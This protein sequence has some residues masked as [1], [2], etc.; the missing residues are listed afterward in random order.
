MLYNSAVAGESERGEHL[1]TAI[2][3]LCVELGGSIT[4]EHG[5]GADKACSM[6]KMFSE[7]D[8]AVMKRLRSAFDPTGISNPGKLFPTPRLC[9]ERPGPYKAHP[10]EADGLIERM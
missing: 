9:G 6:S 4:G 7:D 10:L 3:E 1:S 2:A 8:L 5:V